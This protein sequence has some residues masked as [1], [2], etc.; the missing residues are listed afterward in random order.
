MDTTPEHYYGDLVRR[1]FMFAAVVMVVGLPFVL[2]DVPFPLFIS[3][4]AILVIGI[5][6]GLTN[7]KHFW[8][9]ILN[10]LI[11]S[12]AILTFEWIAVDAYLKQ[13]SFFFVINQLLAIIFLFALYYSTKTLRGKMT[14]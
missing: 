11:S 12:V 7:P 10:L 6:A 5:F 14:K 4:F 3:L 13:L 8:V 2:N 1:L 9:A